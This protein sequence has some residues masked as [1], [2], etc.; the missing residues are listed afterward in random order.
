MDKKDTNIELRSKPIQDLIGKV[1]P[2][3]VRVGIGSLF[4]VLIAIIIISK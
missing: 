2:K 3:V 1:P 4:F